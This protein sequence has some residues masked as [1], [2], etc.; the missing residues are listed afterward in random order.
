MRVFFSFGILNFMKVMLYL[1]NFTRMLA[2]TCHF[3]FST[4]IQFTLILLLLLILDN[5][6]H[7]NP[8]PHEYEFSVFHLNAGSVRNKLSYLED[9]ASGSYIIYVTES[10]LDGNILDND[11]TIE[12]FSDKIFRK[13]RNSFGGGV[14]VYTSQ[15]ICVSKK[16]LNKKKSKVLFKVGTFTNYKHKLS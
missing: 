15:G 4:N 3:P 5:D 7:Q 10:H 1:P 12:G 11:I 13:D 2:Q 16:K 8:G 9:I 14:L 6:I